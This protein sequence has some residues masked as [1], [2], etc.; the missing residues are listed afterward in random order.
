[1]PGVFDALLAGPG[2]NPSLVIDDS[3][4]PEIATIVRVDQF[5]DY[6][7]CGLA[8]LDKRQSTR[9]ERRIGEGLRRDSADAS[10]GPGYPG[11][12]TKPVTFALPT[13]SPVSASR[14]TIENVWARL[15]GEISRAG[16]T[17]LLTKVKRMPRPKTS[18]NFMVAS[19]IVVF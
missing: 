11:A 14:A 6:L 17:V 7:G 10:L 9:P 1:M 16:R 4:L 19:G 15:P 3:K 18:H 2:G 13:I 8:L 12:N 5:F